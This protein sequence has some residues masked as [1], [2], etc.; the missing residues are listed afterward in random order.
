MKED[1]I[2]I[3]DDNF[4]QVCDICDKTYAHEELLRMLNSGNVSEKQLAALKFDY[5]RN[6]NDANALLNNLT[7]CDGKIREAVAFTINKFIKSDS[8]T[9]EIFSILSAEIFAKASIDINANICRFVIDT[10]PY[11]IINKTF[12]DSYSLMI[13]NFINEALEELSKFI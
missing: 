12:A 5:I 9:A 4:E 2:K 3:F 10:I 13:L 1:S 7:G 6:S 8:A 11:L